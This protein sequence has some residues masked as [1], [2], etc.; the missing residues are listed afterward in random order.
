MGRRRIHINKFWVWA[1][2][3]NTGT[4]TLY[5]DGVIA[6]E[7]WFEDDIT[8]TAFREELFAGKGDITV[9]INSPGGDVFAA[10]QIYTMLIEY[11][12]NVTVKVDG[13]A[14]SAAS[15]VAMAGTV[16]LMA[17]TAMLMI[18][19]PWSFAIG[20]TSEMQKAIALLDEVKDS[21]IL[22]YEI[23][24]GLPR[25]E[26]SA[27]MDAETWISASRAVALGF[28]DGM[29]RR[30]GDTQ[31][32][33]SPIGVDVVANG[34][35]YSRAVYANILLDKLRHKPPER[36]PKTEQEKTPIADLDKRLALLM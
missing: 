36:P 28:A 22:A 29:L 25:S 19:N 24:T 15:V 5:L 35:V 23:K 32:D 30:G 11:P 17:P 2:D 18:H 10:S 1:K 8:P 3:A 13:L 27:M 20:D 14:A 6:S 7:S 34:Y 33:G 26:L 21:I 9:Y 12:Y 4:R 31:D 16:V